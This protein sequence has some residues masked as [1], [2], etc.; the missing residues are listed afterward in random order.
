MQA[1]GKPVVWD[2][3]D[4]MWR[5][6][7]HHFECDQQVARACGRWAVSVKQNW[8]HISRWRILTRTLL[9]VWLT[10]TDW[11]VSVLL[12]HKFY[13]VKRNPHKMSHK[14]WRVAVAARNTNSHST[15]PFICCR[16]NGLLISRRL[17]NDLSTLN[18]LVYKRL[19]LHSR[20]GWW[21]TSNWRME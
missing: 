20:N 4:R 21:W 17:N 7:L 10:V 19:G 12:V 5:N 13:C 15:L 16:G 8:P 14:Q 3:P 9:T 2:K 1:V 6:Q 18:S 11:A